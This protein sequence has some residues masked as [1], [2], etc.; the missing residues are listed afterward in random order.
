M[1]YRSSLPAVIAVG[2]YLYNPGVGATEY[3]GAEG[4]VCDG[5]A[6]L[7]RVYIPVAGRITKAFIH[8][9]TWGGA[10]SG[11]NWSLYIRLNNTSD[12]LIQTTGSAS[13]GRTWINQALNIRVVPGD[14]IEIKT[15]NPGWGTAPTVVH[16]D[17]NIL[18]ECE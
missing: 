6:D 9:Y 15:V 3:F 11:D 1:G 5:S 16:M 17:G 12:T 8:S 10:S 18:I 4:H 14:Y 2:S 13:G 7:K